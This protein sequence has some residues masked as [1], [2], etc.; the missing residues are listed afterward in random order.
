MNT[1]V[2][3]GASHSP[4]LERPQPVMAATATHRTSP[5]SVFVALLKREFW[6]HRGGLWTGQ[7]WTT[8]ILL[9][10]TLLSVLIGEA[11]RVRLGGGVDIGGVTEFV[12]SQLSESDMAEYRR[13]LSIGLWAIGL[14]NQIVLYFVVLFYCIN[15]LYDER[16]DRSILFWK[17]LPAT[18]TQ[19]VLSKLVTAV[20]VAPVLAMVAIAILHVGFLLIIALYA[21]IQGVN[22]LP[23]LWQPGVYADVWLR[24][25]ATIPVHMIWAIPGI[26]WLLLASSWAKRAPFVWAVLV[27]ILAG[28]FVGML[29]A[30]VRLGVPST[31]FWE[32]V[33]TRIFTSPGTMLL[34]PWNWQS[35]VNPFADSVSWSHLQTTLTA[36]ATWIGLVIG[37]GLLAA[38]IWLRRYR[39][40]S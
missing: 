5:V 20:L 26:A 16:K 21:V 10:M 4:A 11:F 8:G 37:L 38:A 12:A 29:D 6:E 31:W 23:F 22:P 35:A 7:L 15:T 34:K 32:N 25:L 18:D 3:T 28:V 17:S 24:M 40:D 33:V 27:P 14:I 13:G 30:L 1:T 36:P 39:D 2:E 19:T 9:A